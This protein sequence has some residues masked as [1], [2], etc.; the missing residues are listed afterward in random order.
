MKIRLNHVSNS[1]SASFILTLVGTTKDI[2]ELI[3]DSICFYSWS[4]ELEKRLRNDIT[5]TKNSITRL[6]QGKEHFLDESI[7]ELK[8]RIVQLES[9]LAMLGTGREF[10]GRTDL[11]NFNSM[12]LRNYGISK[13]DT[14]TGVVKLSYFTSMHNCYT[15]SLPQI[16][17]ELVLYHAFEKTN[18]QLTC[19]IEKDNG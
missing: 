2:N 17:H 3:N 10:H 11:D 5:Y 16:I 14:S 9:D 4:D 6:E 13:T 18:I 15:E 8:E 19:E 12:V 1:S 7:D